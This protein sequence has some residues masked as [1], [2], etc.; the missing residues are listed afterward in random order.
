MLILFTFSVVIAF[1][2][3]KIT[4]ESKNISDNNS[5]QEN[6]ILDDTTQTTSNVQRKQDSASAEMNT[7]SFPNEKAEDKLLQNQ[8]LQLDYET[9]M[10]IHY[11]QNGE[12]ETIMNEHEVNITQGKDGRLIFEEMDIPE[13]VI[14]TELP[15]GTPLQLTKGYTENDYFNFFYY[16][17]PLDSDTAMNL[18]VQYK[19]VNGKWKL[20]NIRTNH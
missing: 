15:K 18:F 10:I 1:S 6:L 7:F 17:V 14:S 3:G 2:I 8:F 20:V 4:T 16:F 9:R 12:L 5:H 11:I 19:K 13:L